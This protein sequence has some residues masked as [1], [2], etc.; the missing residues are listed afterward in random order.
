MLYRYEAVD[1]AGRLSA[2]TTEAGS[3]ADAKASLR[4]QGLL[5]VDL[6]PAKP[7]APAR[8]P[9]LGGSWIGLS[10]R[11]LD[12]LT[13]AT[14]HLALLLRAGVALGQGLGVL[15]G[16][17]QDKCFKET[18]EDLASRVRDGADFD[19]A[20]AAHPRWFPVLFVQVVRAGLQAGELPRVL[21][22]VAAYYQRQKKIRDRVV[23]ALTYPALMGLV[24]VMILSFLLAFVVPKVAEVL[25]EQKKSLPWPTELLLWAS[26]LVTEHG[27]FLLPALGLLLIGAARY[28][29]TERGGR[30]RDRLLLG[31]PGLGDLARKQH[32]ARWAATMGTLVASG[33][34]VAQALS[35][36]RGAVG[37]PLLADDLGRVEREVMEGASLS[38]ALKRST[39]LPP[40]IGFVAGVGEETGELSKVLQEIAES[41]I[42]EVE[43]AAGRLTELLNPILIVVLGVVVGFIVA[44]ILLPITDF[45]QVQ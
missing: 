7:E 45:S 37:S 14:R 6:V 30:F 2:G 26:G 9:S 24:G 12:L 8:G 3:S 34:P 33:V 23:S 40:A 16:Q 32:V 19:A 18:I 11:R 22:E 36:V 29:S 43:I 42:E 10:G 20:L 5:A 41:Y 13:Q 1:E 25:L 21:G 15:A 31:L 27:W 28:L 4:E 38:E 39:V 44:A 35:V 17:I